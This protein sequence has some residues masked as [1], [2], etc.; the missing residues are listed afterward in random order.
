MGAIIAFIFLP[1]SAAKA[2]FLSP[3]QKKLAFYRIQVDSSSVVDEKFNFR[4][5][6]KILRHPTSWVILLIQMCLGIPLQSVSL[7]LPQ[8]IGRLGYGKV[9]T[10]LY[11]V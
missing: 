8:I 3:E 6:V 4:E 2:K 11:T 1:Y 7:F 9:K 10:N 5:A